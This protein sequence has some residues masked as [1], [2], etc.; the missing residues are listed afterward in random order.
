MQA[1]DQLDAG[2]KDAYIPAAMGKTPALFPRITL[3]AGPVLSGVAIIACGSSVPTPRLGPHPADAWVEVPYPPPAA[4]VEVVPPQPR[5]DAVWVD[6][7]WAW[8]GRYFVWQRGA[9]VIPP[10]HA[11]FSRWARYYDKDGTL[12]F[13]DATWR[14]DNGRPLPAPAILRTAATP[15]ERETPETVTTP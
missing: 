1:R 2:A 5:S 13:A 12:Y 11:Y 15:P 9:W 14:S 7:Q 6:G 4:A 8:R 10:A 3:R